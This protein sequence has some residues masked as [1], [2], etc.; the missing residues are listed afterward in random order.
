MSIITLPVDLIFYWY[1]LLMGCWWII[2]WCLGLQWRPSPIVKQHGVTHL[3]NHQGRE[4]YTTDQPYS[5]FY[6]TSETPLYLEAHTS[7]LF[8]DTILPISLPGINIEFIQIK[9]LWLHL[10]TSI[11]LQVME[12]SFFSFSSVF[13]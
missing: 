9:L 1:L 6:P 10:F 4:K 3:Q 13:N 8:N 7:H 12:I 11:F 2:I 5:P